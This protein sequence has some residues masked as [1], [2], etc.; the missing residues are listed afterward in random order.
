MQSLTLGPSTASTPVSHS[1]LHSLNVTSMYFVTIASQSEPPLIAQLSA[2]ATSW[3][4]S[5]RTCSPSTLTHRPSSA[6]SRPSPAIQG[7]LALLV[8]VTVSPQTSSPPTASMT[9]W[10]TLMPVPF[11]PTPPWVLQYPA[12]R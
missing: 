10:V 2:T 3:R 5:W 8:S 11:L 6:E 7:L 1:S 4:Y 12:V 9:C